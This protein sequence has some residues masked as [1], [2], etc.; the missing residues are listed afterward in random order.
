MD[1]VARR[2]L[3]TALAALAFVGACRGDSRR[4]GSDTGTAAFAAKVAEYV[5]R[6]EREVGVKF[7]TPPKLEVRSRAQV[8][9]FVLKQ[10]EDSAAQRDLAGK[11]AAYK[12][13]GLIPDTMNVRKLLVDLYSEQ[14]LG[15]Y[16]P[17]TKVLYVVQGAPEEY[18]NITIMHELVHALQDQY[19]NLDSVQHTIGDDDRLA[20]AQAVIEGQATYEQ[21]ALM[22]GGRGNIGANLPGGWERMRNLI[23]DNIS[24]QPVFGAAPMVIQE[25]L[26]FPYVN[27]AEFVRRFKDHR[28][29]DLPFADMPN[30]TEQVLHD[31]AFFGAPRDEPVRVKL[32]KVPGSIYENDAGEFETRLFLFEPTQ[33]Q[34]TS[35]RAAMGWAGDRYAVVRT[36]KGNGIAWVTVWDTPVDAAEFVD[37]VGLALRRRYQTGTPVTGANGERTFRGHGRTVVLTPGDIQGKNA[38]LMVDVPDGVSPNIL[39]LGRVTIG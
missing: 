18:A 20:A 4:S 37:A 36:P 22:V 28:P 38:V 32:P 5:P 1:G 27:G 10:L 34:D 14:I 39:D 25:E 6:I 35:I 13:L 26:L 15:Y 33:D 9:D 7:K 11:E 30:S 16:D 2:V 24:A 23:R 21:M 19:V 29:K 17:K 12:V 8:R 3:V 31:K